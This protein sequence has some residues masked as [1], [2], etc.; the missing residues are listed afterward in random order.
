MATVAFIGGDGAGKTTI[1]KALVERSPEHRRYL[2][3]GFNPQAGNYLLPTTRLILRWKMRSYKR[4]AAERGITDPKFLTTQHP[5]HRRVE[6]GLLGR[7]ARLAHRLTEAWYR[8]IVSWLLQARG[9]DIVYDRHYLFDV[10]PSNS[11]KKPKTLDRRVHFWLLKRLYPRPDIVFLLDGPAGIVASRKGEVSPRYIESRRRAFLELGSE[12][13]NFY[14]LDS[15]QTPESLVMEVETKLNTLAAEPREERSLL[16]ARRRAASSQPDIALPPA[17]VAGLDSTQGLQTA[18]ILARHGIPVIGITGNPRYYASKTNVC[19]HIIVAKTNKIAL[20]DAL[21]KLGPT[22]PEKAV[23]IPCVDMA[24]K[25]VSEHRALLENWFHLA[26]PKADTVELLLNKVEFYGYAE[27][28][29]LPLPKT[30][31]LSSRGDAEKAIEELSFPCILKPPWRPNE[32]VRHTKSK[33]FWIENAEEL[34]VA[35]DHYSQWMDVLI[36]QDWIP[37]GDDHHYSCNV[38][39]GAD[40]E[41]LVTFVSQKLRQWPPTTGRGCLATEARNEAVLHQTIELF[42]SLSYRGLG[43]LEMKRHAKTGKHYIIEPNVGRPTGRAAMAEAAGVE[44]IYTM[45]CDL[46]GLPHPVERE[47]QY[48]GV[49]WV[50]LMR[51]LQASWYY[52]RS[53]SLTL[54]GWLDSMRGEKAFAIISLRDP[55]PFLSAVLAAFGVLRSARERGTEDHSRPLAF[56][57]ERS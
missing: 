38:Y 27:K 12:M 49:K 9:Y 32:W 39:F 6:R 7:W 25:L 18:R 14:V 47:Q 29:G 16:R 57:H 55:R 53:G 52:W 24:V 10:A 26:L 19:E 5:E 33:A 50:H 40:S 23:L 2:Y 43:Y 56:G 41:P 35:Y 51:D 17:V 45:Y 34:L 22:L 44:L 28:L 37:G 3:M 46:I 48:R 11:T 13:R 54:R 21:E 20:I 8:Q 1:A 30:K 31:V 15:T 42:K 36:A 4:E